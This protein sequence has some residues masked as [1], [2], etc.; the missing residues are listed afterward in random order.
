[1]PEPETCLGVYNDAL[2]RGAAMRARVSQLA[3]ARRGT[4]FARDA[5]SCAPA[6]GTPNKLRLNENNGN[7]SRFG[8]R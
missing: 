7:A 3:F 5:G 4:R 2:L 1:M 6:A 8:P